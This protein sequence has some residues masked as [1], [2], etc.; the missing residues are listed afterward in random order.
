MA[1]DREQEAAGSARLV[2]VDY[3][4]LVDAPEAVMPDVFA[5][6]DLDWT[7]DVEERIRAWR[8]ENP[9]GKRGTHEYRLDDYG[10]DRAPRRGGLRRLHRA[11][12]HPERGRARPSDDRSGGVERVSRRPAR[13]RRSP[14]HPHRDRTGHPDRETDVAVKMFGTVMA[15]YLTH[16]WAEPE[17]PA[18]LPSVGYYQMYGSPNPDTIYRN[19]AID[20]DG[21]YRIS[22]H[23]GTTPDV[24]IMPFGP[25]VPGGL[26]TFAPFHFDDLAIEADGTFE[27]VLS[28]RRPASAK[29]WWRLEPEMRTLMLRIVS[30]EW[31]VH[32][33]PRIAIVR[34]DTDP[35]RTRTEPDALRRRFAVVRHGGGG[36][37]HVGGQPGRRAACRRRGEPARHGRLR[38]DRRRASTTSGTRKGASRSTTT[39]CSCSR[40]RSTPSAG[41]S[42]SR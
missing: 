42:R 20:G 32:T 24:S 34:L 28:A 41:R 18:F 8:A 11:V 14:A 38:G 29:N 23:R 26:Q 7:P 1:F 22:G 36:H 5:A 33:E 13:G 16:L 10:L 39:R 37:G 30:D 15:T 2:H 3:Y 12:R 21:E 9:K 40:R 27:V 6:I 4:A 25:P 17:H 35:R 31:G 19:A